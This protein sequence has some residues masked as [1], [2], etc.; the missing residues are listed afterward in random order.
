[1]G[2]NLRKVTNRRP[3]DINDL[4]RQLVDEATGEAPKLD[5]DEGKNPAAVELGRTGRLEG[6]L[7]GR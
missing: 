1:M 6:R 7:E 5:P 4:A 3:R 2:A